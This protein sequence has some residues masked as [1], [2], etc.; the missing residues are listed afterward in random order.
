MTRPLTC[1]AAILLCT[2]FL[3]AQT[4]IATSSPDPCSLVTPDQIK[5]LI[6]TPVQ[7]GKPGEN[8]CTWRDAKGETRVYIA[9]KDSQNFH[10]LR[11]TMQSTGRLVPITGVGEDAFFVS[12]TGSSAAL[13]TLKK[14]HV[15]LLTVDGP[16]FSKADNEAAEKSLATQVL[17]KL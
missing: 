4:H 16:A 1:A 10:A 17:R 15:L 11:S 14:S 5:T 7:P 8:E 9:L 12:S 6:G 2:A 13:Y 3:P